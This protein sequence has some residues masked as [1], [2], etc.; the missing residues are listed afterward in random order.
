MFL[1]YAVTLAVVGVVG[2]LAAVVPFS[3]FL[4]DLLFEVSPADR[5]PYAAVAAIPA[6]RFERV[7]T[8]SVSGR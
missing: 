3:R 6:R 5:M 2:G 4:G 8:F 1:R 7:S